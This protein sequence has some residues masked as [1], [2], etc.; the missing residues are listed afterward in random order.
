MNNTPLHFA[1]RATVA[2]LLFFLLVTPVFARDSATPGARSLG[3]PDDLTT[4]LQLALKNS[5]AIRGKRAEVQA[6][7]H[8]AQGSRLSRL[9]TLSTHANNLNDSR[10]QGS[11]AL[12]QPVYTFGRIKANIRREE[13]R[14]A[15][16]QL[17]LLRIRQN[18]LRDVAAAYI[19]V[20]H[21]RNREDAAQLNV[22][23]HQELHA[24]IE[25][26]QQGQLSSQADVVVAR[27][28]LLQA[29][30]G[31]EHARV[32]LLSSE[33]ELSSVVGEEVNPLA[34][35]VVEQL[36]LP[37]DDAAVRSLALRH[38]AEVRYKNGQLDLAKAEYAANK[39]ALLP[40]ISIRFEQELLDDS[41][42]NI[43]Q[44][45]LGLVFESS[46]EGLGWVGRQRVKGFRE[47]MRAAE[48]DVAYSR[49]ELLRKVDRL[50]AEWH[51]QTALAE[52]YRQVVRALQETAAST[53]RQYQAGRRSW[54]DLLNI[55][56]EVQQQRES[57]LEAEHEVRSNAIQLA[58]LCGLLMPYPAQKG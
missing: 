4:V 48:F 14:L 45:R 23:A 53:Q 34:E 39:K 13:Q 46:V 17:D 44:T 9:P 30:A 26:R 31:R 5:P 24:L 28:R 11:I 50:L 37:S 42:V 35:L 41:L 21:A 19:N 2:I 3:K 51:L 57:V 36:N 32:Q 6:Q 22:N 1:V 27:S 55:Q 25:R 33:S 52:N 56:R 16:E 58:A 40:T 43:D 54:L 49:E 38:A 18:L 12:S 15:T 47:H 29:V 8:A 7:R 10:D 20:Q